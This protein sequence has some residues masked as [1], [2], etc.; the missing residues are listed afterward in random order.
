MK[1][2]I[3]LVALVMAIAS[4]KK[5]E[6]EI[7]EEPQKV[8][9]PAI[10]Q[11]YVWNQ[12]KDSI[13]A[14][15]T[16]DGGKVSGNLAYRFFEKDKSS[17]PVSGTLKGDTLF[18]D[19]TFESE[20]TR[21]VREVVFLKTRNNLTEG[22]ADMEERNGKMVFRNKSLLKFDPKTELLLTPCK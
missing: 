20:G 6:T 7:Y 9:E 5:K 13:L 3:L 10:E 19:Y 18:L 22:Y 11:C 4:C 17:G 2:T 12:G 16:I 21:S 14:N 1:K 15:L 8:A